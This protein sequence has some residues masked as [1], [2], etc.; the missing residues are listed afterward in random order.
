[1]GIFSSIVSG[2]GSILGGLLSG[3]GS[4]SSAFMSY[5]QNKKLMEQNQAWQEKMSNTAHQREVSD[6]RAAGLNP[7]LSATGGS[8]ASFGSVSNPG[9]QVGDFGTTALNSALAV[10]DMKNQTKLADSTEWKQRREASL[11]G[12]Q[13]RNEAERF[14]SIRQDR[15]NSIALTNAQI[16][17]LEANSAAAL[18]NASTNAK[19]GASTIESNSASAYYNRKLGEYKGLENPWSRG[20]WLGNKLKELKNQR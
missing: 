10:K 14:D 12:E 4:V 18:Q 19:V 16:R 1:M 20:Y 2:A 15:A 9:S 3:A 6:L 8:G 5:D 17:N 13:A 11:L 7:I